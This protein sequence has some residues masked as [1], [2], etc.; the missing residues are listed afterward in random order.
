MSVDFTP[1]PP[2]TAAPGWICWIMG[3]PAMVAAA[4]QALVML[5]VAFGLHL[6]NLQETAID[7]ATLAVL[8][9]VVRQAVVPITKLP[10]P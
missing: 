8:S 4:V 5:A 9:V 7:T 1:P 10:S 6:S 3:E 2:P